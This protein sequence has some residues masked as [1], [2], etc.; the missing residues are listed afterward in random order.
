MMKGCRGGGSTFGRRHTGSRL[1]ALSLVVRGVVGGMGCCAG[2]AAAG[3]VH[4]MI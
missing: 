2:L 4:T 1:F 3:K